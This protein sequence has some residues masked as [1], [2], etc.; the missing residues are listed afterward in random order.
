MVCSWHC[1]VSW[2][3]QNILVVLRVNEHAQTQI[4]LHFLLSRLVLPLPSILFVFL[5]SQHCLYINTFY[6][7]RGEQCILKDAC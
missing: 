7:Q 3:S 2:F 4:I 1:G 5:H 6:L